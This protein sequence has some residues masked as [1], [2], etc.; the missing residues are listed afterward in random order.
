MEEIAEIDLLL[1]PV[2]R[3]PSSLSRCTTASSMTELCSQEYLENA[4]LNL[5]T[6]LGI[7]EQAKPRI[8]PVQPP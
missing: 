3:V 4:M 7:F 6:E 8:L 1:N 2:P 5:K